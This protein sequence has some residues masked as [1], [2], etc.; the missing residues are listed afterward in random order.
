MIFLPDIPP[1]SCLFVDHKI[2][3]V[4]CMYGEGFFFVIGDFELTKID[5]KNTGPVLADTHLAV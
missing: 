4:I 3:P 2:V 5:V 1:Q